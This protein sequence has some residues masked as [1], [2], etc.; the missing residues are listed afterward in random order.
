MTHEGLELTE[1]APGINIENDIL[2]HMDFKPV[3]QMPKLM[4]HR[5]FK[6]EPMGLIADLL[7]S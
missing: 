1:I 2:R 5:I 6:P 3:I 4:D 7:D